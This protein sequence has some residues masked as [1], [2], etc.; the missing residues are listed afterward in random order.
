LIDALIA[1]AIVA[2]F[3]L[4]LLRALHRPAQSVEP[5]KQTK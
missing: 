3:A 5:P 4:G 2:I 1:I